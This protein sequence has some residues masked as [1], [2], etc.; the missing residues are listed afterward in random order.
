MSDAFNFEEFDKK[1]NMAQFAKDLEEAKNN[2]SADYPEIPKGTYD[3]KIER[4]EIKPTKTTNEPMFSVM[5]RIVEGEFKNGCLFFNRKIYGNKETDKWN[6]AKAV[7]SV[8]SWL[9]KLETETIPEFKS[10]T[11]FNECILDIFEECEEYGVTLSVEY[12][13][14]KF[15]PVS[16]KEV[17]ED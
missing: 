15:N 12:D 10:Y 17:F 6:D 14:D 7:Q 1:L 13:P 8:I 3:V 11:Q 16:I 4:M 5:L 2:A 9:D